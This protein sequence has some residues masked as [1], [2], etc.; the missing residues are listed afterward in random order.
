MSRKEGARLDLGHTIQSFKR[1][2]SSHQEIGGFQ[3]FILDVQRRSA[4]HQKRRGEISGGS[5]LK[6][7]PLRRQGRLAGPPPAKH[8][9]KLPRGICTPRTPG[10]DA[11]DGQVFGPLRTSMHKVRIKGVN[12]VKTSSLRLEL[13]SVLAADKQSLT[14]R[15][16][17]GIIEKTLGTSLT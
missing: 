8:Y 5:D 4:A 11:V 13:A 9:S 2:R 6:E 17:G 15:V 12:E 16:R 10:G 1:T 3:A 14:P 7:D